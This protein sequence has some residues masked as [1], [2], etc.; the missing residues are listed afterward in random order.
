MTNNNASG[1]VSRS[2]YNDVRSA[3]ASQRA[4]RKARNPY[5]VNVGGQVKARKAT[6][7]EAEASAKVWA[8]VCGRPATVC[9]P[10]A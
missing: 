5:T 9:G 8:D 6:R 2:T 10:D 1:C 3:A 4:A 7:A